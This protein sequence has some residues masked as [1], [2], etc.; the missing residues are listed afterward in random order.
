MIVT[1][2]P[3]PA[4][5]RMTVFTVHEPPGAPLDRIDRAAVMAFVKDGFTWG[6]FLL[7]PIW[8]L[9]NRL[10]LALAGYVVAV[11]AGGLLLEAVGAN[12]GWHALLVL[13]LNLIVGWEAHTLKAAKL[14]AD[15]W[16]QLGS[17]SGNGLNDCE[18][19][20]FEGWLP[21]QQMM[22]RA[23]PQPDAAPAP[24]QKAAAPAEPA[25]RAAA[26]QAPVKRRFAWFRR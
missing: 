25:A 2:W 11:A 3:F 20:F 21:T 7:G 26:P 19:R 9:G 22:R 17:V 12:H 24:A 14:D 8:L 4:Q 6:A 13:G 18:R 23:A 5:K 16:A 15:G 10:W 1:V